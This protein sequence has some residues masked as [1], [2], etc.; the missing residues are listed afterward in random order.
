MPA[1]TPCKVHRKSHRETCSGVE[2]TSKTKYASIVEADEY[3][4]KRMDESLHKSHEDHIAGKGMNSSS[5][6]TMEHK[7]IPMP[8]AMK[9]PDAEAAV[10]KEWEKLEKI[11]AWQL[12]KV[13]NKK[14]VIAVRSRFGSKNFL[15]ERACDFSASRAFLVLSCPSVCNP[16]L[17]FPT[18][19]HGVC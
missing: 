7:F 11:P 10:D 18:C 15:F 17:L 14:E 13:R 4:R 16:V 5:H 12:T 6:Y 3:T 2:N 9:M 8:Q 1:A 19:S